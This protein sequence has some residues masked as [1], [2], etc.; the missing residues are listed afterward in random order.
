MIL[1]EDIMR[2]VF[3][4]FKGGL[5]EQANVFILLAM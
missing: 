2:R 1:Q 3:F 5:N 4:L